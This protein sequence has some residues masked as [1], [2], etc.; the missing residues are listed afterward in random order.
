MVA[1]GDQAVCWDWYCKHCVLNTNLAGILIHCRGYIQNVWHKIFSQ[2]FPLS[3]ILKWIFHPTSNISNQEWMVNTV[4][5]FGTIWQGWKPGKGWI[6]WRGL[7]VNREQL[8]KRGQSRDQLVWMISK[9]SWECVNA[10]CA[11]HILIRQWTRPDMGECMVAVKQ[12]LQAN[13]MTSNALSG[14]YQS[15]KLVVC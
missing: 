4:T 6:P 7:F 12:S 2:I 13:P 15:E 11:L 14:I 10:Q 3:W 1:S 8:L 9:A 5:T